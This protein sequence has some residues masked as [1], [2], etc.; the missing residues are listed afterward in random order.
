MKMNN[1]LFKYTTDISDLLEDFRKL[2]LALNG[3]LIF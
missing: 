2:P 1:Y 3:I